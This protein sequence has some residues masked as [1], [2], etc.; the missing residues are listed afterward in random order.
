MY[1]LFKILLLVQL[2]V[3]VLI[4]EILDNDLKITA[5][6]HHFLEYIGTKLLT[7][8]DVNQLSTMSLPSASLF[9]S[10]MTAN[11]FANSLCTR[12]F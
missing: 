2:P 11:D 8:N 4:D 9:F 10:T 7:V 1:I 3:H 12:P 5:K 6:F